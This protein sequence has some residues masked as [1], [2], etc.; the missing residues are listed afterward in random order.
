MIGQTVSHYRIT[1]K[2]GGG[3]MGVV[4][5]AEDTRLGRQVAL[6]FLPEDI[7][8]DPLALDRFRREARAASAINHPHICTVYDIGEDEAGRPFLAMEYLEG[9]TLKPRIEERRMSFA[10]MLEWSVQI[11][12]ALDAAHAKGIVHRDIKPANLFITTR[13]QAKVLDFGLAKLASERARVGPSDNTATFS[14]GFETTPGMTMGTICYM[15]PEQASG[16]ELDVRT[17]I[18]SFGVVL[19]QMA[20]GR[21]PFEGR[22]SALVFN[23]ILS[24]NPDPPSFLNH[25]LPAE[26]D[27][28]VMRALEKDRALRYQSAA[29]LLAD[30]RRLQRDTTM[31]NASSAVGRRPVRASVNRLWMYGLPALLIAL[32]AIGFVLYRPRRLAPPP[33]D[34]ELRRITANPSDRPV[35]GAF[36]SPDGQYIAYSDPAGIHLYTLQSSQNR[37]LANTAGMTVW[38]WAPGSGKML[39]MRQEI[40]GFP[41]QYSIDVLGG[42]QIDRTL[43]WGLPAPQGT[44]QL[45]WRDRGEMFVEDPSKGSSRPLMPGERGGRRPQRPVWSPDGS[46]I[47]FVRESGSGPERRPGPGEAWLVWQDAETGRNVDAVGPLE[48]PVGSIGW[49][50]SDRLLFTVQDIPGRDNRAGVY[51]AKLDTDG[52]SKEPP[53]LLAKSDGFSYGALSISADG[54]KAALI[55]STLQMDVY[56]GEI[57]AKGMLKGEPR[58]FTLDDRNDRPTDWTAD[59]KYVLFSSD[60]NGN[61]QIFRQAVDSDNAELIPGGPE[62]QSSPKLSPDGLSILFTTFADKPDSPPR[63]MSVPLAGGT[64]RQVAEAPG[65]QHVRCSRFG[66]LLEQAEGP[67]RILFQLD[68]VKGKGREILRRSRGGGD[69]TISP[70]GR[71]MAYFDAGKIHIL[72]LDGRKLRDI[73]VKGVRMLNALDWAVDGKGFY[74]GAEIVSAGAALVYID[75]SG[76]STVVWKQSGPRQIWGVPSPD[77]KYLAIQGATRDSNVWLME[78][79]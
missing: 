72:D 32:V 3:G 70:I 62:R 19:Y 40:G 78:N 53:V 63:I 10:A 1:E 6:K 60:R 47:A 25:E 28:I 27:R 75:L 9:E 8:G 26:F 79:F 50:G 55:R 61:S 66:C 77:G 54:R 21:L 2:I 73:E 45:V 30:L 22:T 49:A 15:S 48:G 11:A 38:G 52:I 33:K 41:E 56:I 67:E 57:G 36:I 64:P 23:A 35:S 17:D 37:L 59:S 18:F 43:N 14:V 13:Q 74:S 69:V 16:D 46:R 12:D 76:Q 58:R 20:T 34:T 44:R 7:A 42:V 39:A 5:R 71:E 31:T 51:V 68:P 24:Q 4:Y 29:D 65:Y